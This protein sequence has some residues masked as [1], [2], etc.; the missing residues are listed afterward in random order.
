MVGN[1]ILSFALAFSLFSMVMY[2][3]TYKGAKNTIGMARLSYHLMTMLVIT[4]SLYLF[5]SIITHNYEYDYI[6]NY[7]NDELSVGLLLSTFW[8]GQEGSF[9]LWIIFAA[10]IGVFLQSYT[11]KRENLETTVMLVYTAVV[12]F[13]LLLVS[14]LLKTPFA[15][16]WASDTFIEIAKINPQ[17]LRMEFLQPFLMSDGQSGQ[18]Y[19]KVGQDLYSM[20]VAQGIDFNVFVIQ[21]KGLNPLLQ[22][23]WMQIHPPILFAGFALATVPFAF[24]VSALIKNYYKDW[25]KQSFPWSLAAAGVLGL[26]I[27]LG[28]YWAYGVL[29]WGGYWAWDP[30]ENSS[31]IPW[32]VLVAVIHT[33]VVQRKSQKQ[34]AEVG[35]FAKTNLLLAVAA[36]VLVLYSTFL[37]RSGVLG[38]SSVH[39]FVD[40]GSLVYLFLLV[41]VLSFLFLG[42]GLVAYRWKS[43][44]EKLNI[45]E[46]IWSRE[47]SL[48][49]AALILMASAIVV[50][51]GT[52]APIFGVSV[53]ITFYDTMHI[54]L[55][56]VM[57][58]VNALSLVLK[59]KETEGKEIFRN[60]R[61]SLVLTLLFAIGFIVLGGVM[62]VMMILLG[63]SAA[64]SLFINAE[65]CIKVAAKNFKKIGSYVAHIGIAV[66]ILGVIG[67][68][69]YSEQTEVDLI[70]GKKQNVL[71]YEMMFTGY[72]PFENNTKYK[73]HVVIN[74]GG[75]EKVISPV[76]Y[77]SNF[78]QSMQREPYILEGLMKDVYISPV[79]YDD[80]SSQNVNQESFSINPGEEVVIGG[81]K[82]K[83][84]EFVKPDMSVMSSGGN[85]EMGAKALITFGEKT[86]E[87]NLLTQ[88]NENGIVNLPVEI[89]EAK[90]IFTLAQ[91]DPMS[92]KADVVMEKMVE[93]QIPQVKQETL[94]IQASIKPF[95]SLVW[96]GVFLIVVGFII[97][98]FKRAKE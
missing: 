71:G 88:K 19:V 45:E 66:F 2:V 92:K 36:F 93:N 9:L 70:K 68:G 84:L 27:M 82:I 52:S 18:T 53:P 38:D 98:V 64:F 22:N 41:F 14:P 5:Y 74:D 40:P 62:D 63:V 6:F 21:G 60:L 20:L 44:S 73:F 86:Q 77:M 13:L 95:V 16:L 54:P 58:I 46:N 72:E 48:F 4:A 35:R 33:M 57:S 3:F 28:G 12:S 67:S 7:S 49:N 85:F 47:L 96:I 51:F 89:K 80:Q 17:F 97:A 8:A 65:I 1:L 29:G 39:S 78:N 11:A 30:V 23:F 69:A 50:F 75:T 32:I 87:I 10:L 55:V 24:A 61:L 26:G 25:V 79:G 43:L 81:V 15:Y 31:L 91:I 37:T 94:S 42:L 59:W 83:Y 34:G 56:I 90:V 76:M